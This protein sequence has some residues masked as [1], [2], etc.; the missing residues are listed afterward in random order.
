MNDREADIHFELYRHLANAL[1]E[2]SRVGNFE[3]GDVRAEHPADGGFADIVLFDS[4]K[5]PYL[6]IEAKRPLAG[7]GYNRN[8]DPF[9][10]KVIR[11]A[12]RYAGDLGAR[13]FATYN[14]RFLVLFRTFEEGTPL[15]QRRSRGYEV[16]DLRVFSREL[17]AEVVHLDE[18][19]AQWDPH[20]ETF[21]TRL[22][23]FH[24][25]LKVDIRASLDRRLSGDVELLSR[26]EAWVKQQGWD[27]ERQEENRDVFAAQAAYLLMNK[28]LF[29]KI[30]SSEPAYQED[31]PSFPEARDE[32]LSVALA[33]MFEEITANVDFE[34]IYEHDPIFDE[35]AFGDPTADEVTEFLEELESYDLRQFDHDVIGEIY[36]S[37]I[38]PKER[39]DLGQYYTPPAIVSFITRLTITSPDDKVL[40]P[41]CGSGGFLVGAYRQLKELAAEAGQEKS[42]DEILEQLYGV[43]INRFPAHLSAIN[44]ALRD[45]AQRTPRVQILVEDFFQVTLE[46]IQLFTGT[47]GI[48]GEGG[49]AEA[50]IVPAVVDAIVGNPPYIRHERI[51]F[52]DEYRRHLS[53]VGADLNQRADI[54]AYFFTHGSEFLRDGGRLGFITSDAWLNVGYGEG[55]QAFFL[56]NFQIRAVL[57]FNRQVFDDPLVVTCVVILE[58]CGSQEERANNLVHFLLVKER[59]DLDGLID[60]VEG[61]REPSVL[62]DTPMYRS[63]WIR[64]GNLHDE[65]KWGRFLFAPP[66]YWEIIGTGKCVPLEELADVKY[67][68]KTGANGFFYFRNIDAVKDSGVEERFVTNLLKHIAETRCIVLQ[69][70]DLEWHVLDMCDFVQTAISAAGSGDRRSKQDIT[71]DALRQQGYDGVLAYI[72]NGEVREINKRPS[73]NPR[74]VWFDLGELSHPPLILTKEFWTK[75][76][77][78]RNDAGATIDQALYAVTPNY[79]DS[80][81]LLGVLNSTLT[82]ILRELHGRAAAG[83][84]MNRNRLT[85]YEAAAMPIPDPRQFREDQLRRVRES[86]ADLIH[87]ERAATEDRRQ[88]LQTALDEAVLEL[89]GLEE[90]VQELREAAS[91]LLRFRQEGGAANTEVLVELGEDRD[92]A[93]REIRLTGARVMGGGHAGGAQRSLFGD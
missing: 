80:E 51:Q 38:P 28:L 92:E 40:D 52:K 30:L 16:T 32:E 45:L 2:D 17:L 11:Q 33:R 64:Q 78:L 84:A 48:S 55:L 72:E 36:Q 8:L 81:F 37:V 7:G 83:E 53:S 75:W 29:Y 39:H 20:H 6:V 87:E 67:V 90:Q 50:E 10:P 59:L 54:Y 85:R 35:A 15:L 68:G 13:F 27:E 77:T 93:A 25:R 34:A 57:V 82:V 74:P 47:A 5:C 12:F 89:F 14:G 65:P 44:L 4:R 71:K 88:E 70:D 19:L 3:F 26:L 91:G 23:V 18:G 79:G 9:S 63:I 1:D 21:I 46:Q 42:H 43:D 61:E 69:A 58:K 62:L 76:H 60:M 24:T 41:A 86:V 66:I 31:L 73:I 22:K 49:P 56:D